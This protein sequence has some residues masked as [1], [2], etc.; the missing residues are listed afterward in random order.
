MFLLYLGIEHFWHFRLPNVWFPPTPHP[1]LQAILHDT[2]W[3]AYSLTKFDPIYREI[4]QVK[5]SIV[6]TPLRTIMLTHFIRSIT[7]RDHFC[8]DPRLI[9]E[10]TKQEELFA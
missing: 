6:P 7:L 4:P 8:Y 5:G 9:E 3:V 10:Q 2:S 1:P